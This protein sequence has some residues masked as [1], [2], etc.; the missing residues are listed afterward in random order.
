M[1]AALP[2][3]VTLRMISWGVTCAEAALMWPSNACSTSPI[4][5]R[6]TSPEEDTVPDR[7]VS[8][9][10]THARTHKKKI[11]AARRNILT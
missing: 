7:T 11:L 9:T 4:I 10:S 5:T 3:A 2:C 1:P 8:E 6:I